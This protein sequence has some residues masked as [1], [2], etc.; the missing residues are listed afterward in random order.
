MPLTLAQA[1]E[2]TG[3]SRSMLL[4]AI[5]KGQISASRDAAGGFLVE[6]SELSRVFPI[7]CHD[8][9]DDRPMPSLAEALA[10]LEAA[11]A[12]ITDKDVTIADLRHRLDEERTERRQTAAQLSAAQ[13]RIAALLTHQ[14]ASAAPPTAPRR[15][16][17]RW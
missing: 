3:R 13:E 17:W 6:E 14:G 9:E 16:W 15:R 1:A 2:A 8:A 10:R 7:R 4:R 11:E 5:R 12:R